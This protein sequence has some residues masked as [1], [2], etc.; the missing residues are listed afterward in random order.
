MVSL[1]SPWFNQACLRRR[2]IFAAPMASVTLWN[3]PT[4]S[5]QPTVVSTTDRAKDTSSK[6][7]RRYTVAANQCCTCSLNLGRNSGALVKNKLP[8]AIAM[9]PNGASQRFDDCAGGAISSNRAKRGKD[10]GS[11]KLY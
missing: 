8:A 3:R 7:R 11:R 1:N 5:S 9:N 2:S 10:G 6:R 4:Q